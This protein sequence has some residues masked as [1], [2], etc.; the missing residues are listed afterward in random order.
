M[1][2]EETFELARD[3][4]TVLDIERLDRDLFRGFN[5]ADSRPWPVLYGG[6]V[7]AQALRAAGLTVPDGRFPHSLHGYFLRRGRNDRPVLLQVR[8]DRDGRS[9]SARNVAAIQDGE[10]IFS[11][12]ASFQIDEDSVE[13][14]DE[15]RPPRPA[16]EELTA[17]PFGLLVEVREIAETS[18]VGP[19]MKFSDHMWIKAAHPLPDDRLVHVCA[20]TYV[21]DMGSGFGQVEHPGLAPGGPSLDHSLWFQRPVKLDDWVELHMHPLKAGGGRGLYRGTIRD[22]DGNLAAMLNQEILLRWPSV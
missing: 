11:M 1:T 14:D 20:L 6:Q 8:R 9:F 13:F 22:R 10:V 15:P 7:A 3:L 5:A 19:R 12:V 17:R 4:A 18:M 21:S 16:P 2:A